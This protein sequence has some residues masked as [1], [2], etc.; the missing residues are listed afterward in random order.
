MTRSLSFDSPLGSL[1][2][3][4]SDGAIVRLDWGLRDAKNEPSPTLDSARKQL[5]EY[6]AGGRKQF[7]LPLRLRGNEFRQSFYETL[8]A[9]PHGETRSYGDIADDLGVSPQAIG[10][11]CGANPIPILIPCHRVLAANGLGGFSGKGGVETKAA[12]L[13]LEGAASLLF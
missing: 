3:A 9:I 2:V 7:K 6:F 11:A 4:E 12:L 8:R 5:D 13:K 1:T 10:Q